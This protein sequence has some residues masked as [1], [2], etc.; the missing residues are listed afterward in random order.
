MNYHIDIQHACASPIPFKDELLREWAALA[1]VEKFKTAEVTLRLVDLAEMQ[2]LNN[3]YRQQDK[4]TNVLAFPSSLPKNI[5]L[6]FPLVGDVIICPAMLEEESKT[7][8][9]PLEEHWAHITIHGILHLLGYDH[10]K[11]SDAKLMQA[12]EKGL[13]GLLGF[14]DPYPTEGDDIE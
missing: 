12:V 14:A 5:K 8:N 4:P 7:L 11:E 1:L 13:L 3:R 10:I 9:K 6:K 2:D